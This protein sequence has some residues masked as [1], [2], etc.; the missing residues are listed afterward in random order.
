MPQ[1]R[2]CPV[3]KDTTY[4]DYNKMVANRE[5]D[6]LTENGGNRLILHL[7]IAVDPDFGQLQKLYGLGF[8]TKFSLALVDAI[9]LTLVSKKTD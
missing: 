5:D 9:T 1:S 7:T 4:L 2:A 6:G 8:P 3:Q